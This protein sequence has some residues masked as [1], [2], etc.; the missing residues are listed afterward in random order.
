VPKGGLTAAELWLWNPR[1]VYDVDI[2]EHES[3]IV[4]QVPYDGSRRRADVQVLMRWYVIDPRRVVDVGVVDVPSLARRRLIETWDNTTA[5]EVWATS[6]ALQLALVAITPEVIDLA[7]GI[8]LDR[9]DFDVRPF[10]RETAMEDLATLILG[11]DPLPGATKDS[12]AANLDAT[13]QSM[14][15]AATAAVAGLTNT[16]RVGVRA[17]RAGYAAAVAYLN[18]LDRIHDLLGKDTN[19]NHK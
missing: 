2:V 11:N 19:A 15:T 18:M 4:C 6:S 12:P 9:L 5:S 3:A 10:P 16:R 14:H 7:E 17:A 13:L 8:R 1:L